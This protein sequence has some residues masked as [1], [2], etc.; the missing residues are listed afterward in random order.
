MKLYHG[1]SVGGIEYLEPHG[2][3]GETALAYMTDNKALAAIYARNPLPSPYGWFTYR[4]SSDGKLHYDEYFDMQLKEI[5]S[6][7][8]GYVYTID[9]AGQAC[10][11]KQHE[12]MPW[13]Y[14]AENPIKVCGCKKIP[15]IYSELL[16][17]EKAGEIVL[18]RYETISERAIEIIDKMMLGEISKNDL[19]NKPGDPYFEFIKAH[20]PHLFSQG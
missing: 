9:T 14:T 2:Y 13:V 10:E 6:G 1:S 11:I 16:N 17:L 19:L 8:A 7:R 15:D 4:F 18:H 20:Y 12:R 3:N 5:Y